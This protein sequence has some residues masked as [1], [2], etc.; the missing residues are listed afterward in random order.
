MGESVMGELIEGGILTKGV[1]IG[2]VI[3]NKK[4]WDSIL[5]ALQNADLQTKN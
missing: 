2:E 4:F 5:L 1:Y 3:D